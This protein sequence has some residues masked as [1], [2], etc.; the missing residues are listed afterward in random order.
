M[1]NQIGFSPIIDY[2]NSNETSVK[3]NTICDKNTYNIVQLFNI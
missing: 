1:Y 2:F 3:P